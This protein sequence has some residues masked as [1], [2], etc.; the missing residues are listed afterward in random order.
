MSIRS[1]RGELPTSEVFQVE[2]TAKLAAIYA[3]FAASEFDWKDLKFYYNPI[4]SRLI[5]IGIE[6]HHLPKLPVPGWWLN[7]E[8]RNVP[9]LFMERIFADPVMLRAYVREFDRVSDPAYLQAMMNRHREDMAKRRAV[10]EREFIPEEISAPGPALGRAQARIRSFLRPPRSLHAHY[11]GSSGAG[12]GARTITLEL[13]V[14]QHFPLE[15]IRVVNAAVEEFEPSY[16]ET[17]GG[18]KTNARVDYQTVSFR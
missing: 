10:L 12:I 2:Q 17:L 5:P 7:D 18:K 15:P 1:I 14:L 16:A 13:G 3:L 9:K 4:T 8:T 6:V 11:V